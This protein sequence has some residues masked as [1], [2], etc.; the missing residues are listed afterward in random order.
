MKKCDMCGEDFKGKSWPVYDENHNKQKGLI[1]CGCHMDVPDSELSITK[2]WDLPI[3]RNNN[4][5]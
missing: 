3:V 5:Q 1:S 2:D 4:K